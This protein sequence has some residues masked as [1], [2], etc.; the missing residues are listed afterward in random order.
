VEIY[1][2]ERAESAFQQPVNEQDLR[3]QLTPELSSEKIIEVTELKAGL[4]NNTY[5]VNTSQNAYILKVAPERGADV[6]YNERYLMQRERS[7]SQ[8]LQSLSPLIPEY[9]SF[10]TIGGRDAF[11][12]PLIH[13]RLW[14]EV[15]SSL[16][17]LENAELWKQLGA[18][19]RILNNFCGDQFGYPAPFKCFS[20]WSGFIADNTEGM[21][22][23]CRR[24][25]V[26]CEEV[27]TYH[28]YLPHFSQTLDQ[29]K[30]AKLLHGDLWPK[31]VIID[32]SGA[33]IHIKAVFDGERAF[34]GD[35]ASDW[36]LI[37]Y[38]VP[39][40]FWQ[41]YGENLLNTRDPACIAIYKGMYFILNI[42]E[43]VRFQESNEEPRKR[44]S[45]VNK[46][47]ELLMLSK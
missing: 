33:D 5:R 37:L 4:F 16:S 20:R 25:N 13:G 22:E 1:Q 36:V 26:L 47:L 19:A 8:Q 9:L 2:L 7:I 34:W 3:L 31:N 40:A 44:L 42:L 24:M 17:E 46:E 23:D 12:Q 18:F 21:I 45:A 32:G 35:P 29:V 30:T 10:F 27:E 43:A 38:D 28:S 15:I 41:G 14:H 11:L 6:F 39:K